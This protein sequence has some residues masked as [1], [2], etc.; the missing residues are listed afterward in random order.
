MTHLIRYYIIHYTAERY[1]LPTYLF[2]PIYLEKYWEV[3][4][5]VPKAD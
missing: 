2:F 1:P 3:L 5:K 4:Q